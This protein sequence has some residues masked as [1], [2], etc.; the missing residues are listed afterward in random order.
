MSPSPVILRSVSSSAPG[1][2]YSPSSRCTVIPASFQASANEAMRSSARGSRSAPTP[3]GLER[4]AAPAL[5][6]QR[7]AVALEHCVVFEVLVGEADDY[8]RR[9]RGREIG[10]RPSGRVFDDVVG[11][12]PGAGGAHVSSGDE[13]SILANQF[14][15]RVQDGKLLDASVIE[16]HDRGR[17]ETEPECRRPAPTCR[18]S[19][20][21]RA[22]RTDRE[23]PGRPASRSA[24]RRRARRWPSP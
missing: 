20:S 7:P 10:K 18:R 12:L 22:L 1:T 6:P 24:P 8:A 15:G 16:R 3:F 2:G 9:T 23:I 21:H 5:G 14:D 17:A 13:R 4:S 19:R 11:R